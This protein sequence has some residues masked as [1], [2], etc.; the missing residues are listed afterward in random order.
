MP[1]GNV[2]ECGS[3]LLIGYE[4]RRGR[5]WVGCQSFISS[6]SAFLLLFDR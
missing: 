1:D 3:F 2:V 5:G 6:E 4:K